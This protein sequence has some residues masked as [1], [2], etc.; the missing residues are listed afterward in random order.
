MKRFALIAN[1]ENRRVNYFVDAC[2]R[3]GL[4]QPNV[5][6][7]QDV[8]RDSYP[9]EEMLADSSAL[10]IES[11]G[12]NFAAERE[13]LR[14]GSAEAQ[15]EAQWPWISATAAID[16]AEDHGRL[17]F[18][19]QWYHGWKKALA[20]IQSA[21]NLPIMNRPEEIG[22]L[23]DKQ[24]TQARLANAGLPVA[25]QL[26]ICLDF[27]DLRQRMADQKTRRVFLK[28]CHSSSASGIVALQTDGGNRWQ[29]TSSAVMRDSPDG[30]RLYNALQLQR[31]E[32]LPTISRLVNA[33]CLE[34]ALAEQWFPKASIGGR[35][36]DLRIMVIDGTAT[37][38]VVRTSR[39]PI[40]NLHLGNARG[41]PT[42]VRQSLGE[43]KWAEA[44]SLAEQAAHCFPG[45]HY[46]AIDLM[47]SINRQSFCIAEANA[48]GDLLPRVLWNGM[49]TY[50]AELRIWLSRFS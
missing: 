46:V 22:V 40:T 38:V 17:R 8:L 5:L 16:L 39:S 50:E 43:G 42:V 6:A 35:S 15:E 27:Q 23:F 3:C 2:L 20:K 41:D 44:I 36:Y 4:E 12:E 19:R 28:P 25:R 33:V 10:R 9:L 30:I 21:A 29:A 37:H 34:R 45:C 7:W 32:D 1:P 26:G 24:E 31:S 49:E 13:L 48:F 14:L 18:Q 11:P 47:V